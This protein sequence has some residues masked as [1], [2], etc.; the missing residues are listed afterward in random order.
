[1]VSTIQKRSALDDAWDS[2]KVGL[3]SLRQTLRNSQKAA[4]ARINGGSFFQVGVN[5]GTSTYSTWG[6]GTITAVEVVEL[7]GELL[8]L[9]D[10]WLGHLQFLATQNSTPQPTDLDVYNALMTALVPCRDSYIDA[11]NLHVPIIQ[12]QDTSNGNT[13]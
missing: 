12:Y 11:T 6:V 5:G 10:Y 1:M 13:W 4:Q 3:I 7:W 9:Y 8:M 2:A